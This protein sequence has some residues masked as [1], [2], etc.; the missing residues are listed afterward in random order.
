MI[1]LLI[2]FVLQNKVRTMYG[3]S[4]E[5]Y[6]TFSI[7]TTPSFG[8]IQPALKRLLDAGFLNAKKELSE[9]G[10]RSIYYSITKDGLDELKR[11]LML[12]PL[13]NPINFLTTARIKLYCTNLLTP[14][15][16][17]VLFKSLKLKAQSILIDTENQIKSKNTD[18][19]Q[20][21]ILDNLICEYKNFITLLEGFE[22]AG[23]N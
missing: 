1:E 22:H 14:D 6:N 7:L 21:M 20:R 18:F 13:E 8:T 17:K 2:L 3:I 12:P 15:E 19:Y 23:N 9:G 11:M 16:G 5:I 4:K 10:R